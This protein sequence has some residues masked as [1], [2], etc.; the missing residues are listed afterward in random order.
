[1]QA[2]VPG[3]IE[4]VKVNDI[5]QGS[6]PIRILSL[7]ALPDSHVQDLKE[8]I[9][10]QQAKTKD[11]QELVRFLPVSSRYLHFFLVALGHEKPRDVAPCSFRLLWEK[12]LVVYLTAPRG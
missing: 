8:E 1:M 3:V 4:N 6:N 11:P 5:S 9:R 2:S 10:K 12:K 7:R